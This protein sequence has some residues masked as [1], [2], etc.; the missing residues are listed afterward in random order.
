VYVFTLF[1][2]AGFMLFVVSTLL[3]MD[4]LATFS[5]VAWTN[6]IVGKHFG[7]FVSIYTC[8]YSVGTFELVTF[9]VLIKDVT[10][11]FN[12]FVERS[13]YECAFWVVAESVVE[14]VCA[15]N[16]VY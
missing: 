7:F 15:C 16:V 4:F 12:V 9:A 14:K 11:F 3:L 6:P 8:M 2:V 10:Y 1:N 13:V 5:T